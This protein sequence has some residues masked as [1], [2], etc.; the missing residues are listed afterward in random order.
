MINNVKGI[1]LSVF[2]FFL[3]QKKKERITLLGVFINENK[4]WGKSTESNF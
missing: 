3:L 2:F 1:L 4:F